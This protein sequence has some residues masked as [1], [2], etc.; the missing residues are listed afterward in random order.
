VNYI[1]KDTE[2]AQHLNVDPN[3]KSVVVVVNLPIWMSDLLDFITESIQ[4][5]NEFYIGVNRYCI[6]G[7]DTTHK[8]DHGSSD[9]LIELINRTVL[10]LGFVIDKSGYMDNDQGRYFNFIQPL[11]WAYGTN[12]SN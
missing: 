12:K 4:N 9:V 8:F 11:T 5:S 7:N 2:F 3:S 6:L 1:G 10:H